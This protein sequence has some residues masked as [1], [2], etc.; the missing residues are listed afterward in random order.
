MVPTYPDY[1]EL[2]SK[3]VEGAK[4]FANRH[5]LIVALPVARGGT[6]AEVGVLRG[7]F[8]VTL[9]ETFEPKTF[10]AF[11]IF[12]CH[13]YP[14]VWGIPSAEFFDGLNQ[15]DY[16]R[17]QM[18]PYG[19]RVVIEE[20]LSSKTMPK[21]ETHSFDLV[22]VDGGHSYNE[23]KP[24]AACATKMVNESGIIVFNDYIM[25]D[26]LLQ[27]PYGIVPVVN[28]LIV[29]QGWQVIGFAFHRAMF[30]DIAIRKMK[31]SE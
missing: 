12:T 9:M 25:Y 6:V 4:L 1:P 29:N 18:A 30:C 19:S 31:P 15:L 3:H 11:D 21:Y 2:S 7:D 17:R 23:V 8:S 26:H 13:E 22:Y 24:D 5:D 10:V 20:G 28:D 14:S 16:F 27:A